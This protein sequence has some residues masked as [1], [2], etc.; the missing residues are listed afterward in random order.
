MADQQIQM[1]IE[2]EAFDEFSIRFK[3]GLY[4][5]QRLGQAFYNYFNLHKLTNQDGLL[6]L[7]EKD[8]SEARA[9]IRHL[10]DLH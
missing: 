8:G 5:R 1:S 6:G 2:K 4:G 7:Y 10:F 3:K 9:L